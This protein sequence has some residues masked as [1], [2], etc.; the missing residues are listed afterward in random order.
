MII[1]VVRLEAYVFRIFVVLNVP[2]ISAGQVRGQKESHLGYYIVNSC[3]RQKNA[4]G[5]V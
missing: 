1:L 2:P 3:V 4:L 5:E